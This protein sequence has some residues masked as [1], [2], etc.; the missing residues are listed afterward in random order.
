MAPSL[1]LRSGPTA[2]CLAGNS[3]TRPSA[4]PRR[5]SHTSRRSP[6]FGGMARPQASTTSGNFQQRWPALAPRPKGREA[7]RSASR[8]RP[9]PGTP[10]ARAVA[11]R[12]TPTS[13]GSSILA[14]PRTESTRRPSRRSEREMQTSAPRVSPVLHS[15]THTRAHT[16]GIL[17]RPAFWLWHFVRRGCSKIKEGS[18]L[19]TLYSI[20][21]NSAISGITMGIT[22]A[23]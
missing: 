9:P 2:T 23:R 6:P 4:R 19:I 5:D 21:T 3:S 11:K 18:W 22:L 8:G 10:G 16:Q 15:R 20:L 7:K 12:C 17:Y 13:R 14:M 1:T